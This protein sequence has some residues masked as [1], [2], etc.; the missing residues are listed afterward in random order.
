MAFYGVL[1]Y[2]HR[3]GD[4]GLRATLA[5]HLHD[6]EL[7]CGK[8]HFLGE[9]GATC[10]DVGEFLRHGRGVGVHVAEDELNV[11]V[12]QLKAKRGNNEHEI[13][14]QGEEERLGCLRSELLG[15]GDAGKQRDGVQ[16]PANAEHDGG[17]DIAMLRNVGKREPYEKHDE[18]HAHA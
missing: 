10:I 1:G 3:F 5:E 15:D 13:Q 6:L 9:V 14:K 8:V 18:V 11:A 12:A 17:R 16:A 7:A 4:I 2:E